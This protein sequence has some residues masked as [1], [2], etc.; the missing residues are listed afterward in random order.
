MKEKALRA[1]PEAPRRRASQNALAAGRPRPPTDRDRMDIGNMRKALGYLPQLR[2]VLR[3]RH[4]LELAEYGALAGSALGTLLVAFGQ[5]AALATAPLAVA[6]ALN[7][8]NRERRDRHAGDSNAAIVS[9]VDRRLSDLTERL[10]SM[11]P[12]PAEVNLT[13][14]EQEIADLHKS[15]A[16]LDNKAG[17]VATQVYQNLSTKIDAV[18]QEVAAFSE[19][20][21]LDSIETKIAD[22]YQELRSLAERQVADPEQH[23]KLL[24][25]FAELEQKNREVVWPCLDRLVDNVKHLQS[26]D[27]KLTGTLDTLAKKF[28]SRPE[29]TQLAKVKKVVAQLSEAV[30]QLQQTE[31]IAEL[32]ATTAKLREDLIVLSQQYHQRLEPQQIQQ[33][34]LIVK[35]LVKSVGQLKRLSQMDELNEVV[36]SLSI[37]EDEPNQGKQL[38][39]ASDFD[40]ES[41]TAPVKKKRGTR[42]EF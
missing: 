2:T 36:D 28:N 33:L 10:P 17:F 37:L 21:D 40:G 35:L 20:F 8:A 13:S 32:F 22:L 26:N 14:I 27:V 42:G 11:L 31:V 29:V 5:S 9:E 16:I 7:I 41:R 15:I 4:P 3:E 6:I 23:Q 38:T 24:E 12:R 18:H 1:P 30:S 19:P 34:Q 39:G 25:S